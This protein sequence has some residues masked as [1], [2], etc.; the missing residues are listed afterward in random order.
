MADNLL[1][2]REITVSVGRTI[3]LGNFES[4]RCDVSATATVSE[5]G[6]ADETRDQIGIWLLKHIKQWIIENQ[7]K[8]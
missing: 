1:F 7:R 8:S 6:D 2:I 4:L 5:G 3:N